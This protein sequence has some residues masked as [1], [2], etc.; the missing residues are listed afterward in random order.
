MFA[1]DVAAVF[2]SVGMVVPAVVFV[3]YS[4]SQVIAKLT[5]NE[6]TTAD[7][8]NEAIVTMTSV[9]IPRKGNTLV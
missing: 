9:I 2:S 1:D 3:T 7:N 4:V 5:R 6:E 8:R